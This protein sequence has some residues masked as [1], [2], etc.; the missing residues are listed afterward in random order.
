[1]AA[2]NGKVTWQMVGVITT[3]LLA[4]ASLAYGYGILGGD[5]KT[6]TK[7]IAGLKQRHEKDIDKVS[8]KLDKIIDLIITQG[9]R[10]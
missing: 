4:L 6:N 2:G 3:I 5:V 8:E 10:P 1:M 9:V 7:D